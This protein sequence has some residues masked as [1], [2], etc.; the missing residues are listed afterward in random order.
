MFIYAA[1]LFSGRS[2][3]FEVVVIAGSI[4]LTNFLD[5]GNFFSPGGTRETTGLTYNPNTRSLYWVITDVRF[6]P[7]TLENEEVPLLVK[8]GTDIISL[9][10]AAENLVAMQ[11]AP[12]ID[13]EDIA[14]RLNLPRS[15]SIGD[16]VTHE[17]DNKFWIVDIVNNVY[18]EIDFDGN[19]TEIQEG[20]AVTDCQ[21]RSVRPI[22]HFRNPH[23]SDGEPAFDGFLTYAEMG[24]ISV[25]DLPIGSLTDG[26]V[27]TVERVFAENGSIGEMNYE[28]GDPVGLFY[29]LPN[30]MP[31]NSGQVTGIY[32]WTDACG[33]GQ[34]VE[35][36][37]DIGQQIDEAQIQFV[38]A[39]AAAIDDL[40]LSRASCTAVDINVEVHWRN[41]TD[42]SDLQI[43]RVNTSSGESQALEI[44]TGELSAGDHILIDERISDGVY[45]YRFT[46]TSMSGE[47]HP[48]RTC[49]TTVGRGSVLDSVNYES[50]ARGDS[51]P[52]GVTYIESV[53][54]VN[55]DRIIVV[56]SKTGFGHAFSSGLSGGSMEPRSS[57][58]GPFAQNFNFTNGTTVGIAWAP[59]D[60]ELTWLMHINGQNLIHTTKLIVEN[61][62]IT[63]V[64]PPTIFFS[65]AKRVQA[66]L[67]LIRTPVLGDLDYDAFS[68]Q[69]WA[70]DRMHGVAFSFGKSG[71]LTGESIFK[72]LPNPREGLASGGLSVV[73]STIS[74][75]ELDW[76]AGDPQATEQIR[77][78]YGRTI[79]SDSEKVSISGNETFGY[80][81][82][83]STES[84]N[85]GGLARTLAPDGSEVAFIV[86]RDIRRVFQLKIS[87]GITG[88]KFRRGDANSDGLINLSDVIFILVH[89]FL[90]TKTPICLDAI[91][92]DDNENPLGQMDAA[93]DAVAL[94]GYLFAGGPPPSIPFPHC[95]FDFEPG[96][97]CE[98]ESCVPPPSE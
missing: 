43:V 5:E 79:T 32:H 40:G 8:T 62:E 17:K 57:F 24:G 26:D 95:D 88:Q 28:I 59:D 13:L 36:V 6:D 60:E 74:T 86:A 4:Q 75:L 10:S 48:D 71:L 83:A 80:D 91:D 22:V 25:F 67:N 92:V 70:M 9:Q 82:K 61:G 33:S 27:T 54:G 53:D 3:R 16:I 21:G 18:V 89:V 37:M 31:K 73:D 45:E 77:V 58:P 34:N 81:L 93:L 47:V 66:P 65:D 96:L 29:E 68:R 35:I 1:D 44:A 14:C 51:S 97:S 30:V 94:F 63:G 87:T 84:T 42:L 46:A 85:F 20:P 11:S 41:Y 12:T 39:D 55:L 23:S 50:N 38:S 49:E 7:V 15:G 98:N 56:D 76:I 78:T 19:P 72:Q 64:T 90:G 52:F 2:Y 69:F